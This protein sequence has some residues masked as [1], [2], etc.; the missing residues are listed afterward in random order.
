MAQFQV[1]TPGQT[2]QRKRRTP[3]FPM[4]G[5]MKPFGL[6]P[7]MVHPVLPGET[8]DFFSGKIRIGS[9][10]IKHPF[11]GAWLEMWL[12]YV[13]M[14]D[15]NVN[16]GNMFI[17]DDYATTGYTSG[18]DNDRNFV[19]S[20]QIDW[21][22]RCMKAIHNSYFLDA[23]EPERFID[24][25]RQV[26][27]NNRSWMHSMIFEPTD[28]AVGVTDIGDLGQQLTGY[29]MMQLMQMSELSYEEYL[30]QFGVNALNAKEGDPEILRFYRSWTQPTNMIEPSDGT[31]SSAWFWSEEVRA[32]KPKYFN[33]PGFLVLCGTIRP[34]MYLANVAASMVGEMW[35]FSDWFP[36]YNLDD[37]NA[38]VKKLSSST[39]VLENV[40]LGLDLLYDYTDLLSHGE[41]FHNG[42]ALYTVPTATAPDVAV[43]KDPQDLRGEYCTQADIDA[44]FV[45]AASADKFCFY[46]GMGMARVA[47]H[48]K[49]QTL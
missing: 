35:G 37:P 45:S 19:K 4:V 15:I 22:N 18:A 3:N 43:G 31:P 28:E 44:M 24:G 23:D 38:A 30:K 21:V 46:E 16:L 36:A 41:Q 14:T 8:L 20:G 1:I 39:P 25:V 33:E 27:L 17:S 32:E 9:K 5:G 34:K 26:K 6:Y 11:C 49:D 47:G 48:V 13:K 42:N 40:T 29:Q 12:C 7:L 10:P 2:R